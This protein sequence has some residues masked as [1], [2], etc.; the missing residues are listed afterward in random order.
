LTNVITADSSRRR[1]LLSTGAT[2]YD[3][4]KFPTENITAE[5]GSAESDLA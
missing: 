3:C 1:R 4:Y 5:G 2:E